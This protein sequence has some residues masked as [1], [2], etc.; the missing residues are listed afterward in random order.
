MPSIDLDTTAADAALLGSLPEGLRT[1]PLDQLHPHPKNP[2][3]DVGDVSELADSIREH[4]I[5]QPLLAVP[6]PG[7]PQRYRLVIGHRRHAAA[8]A[9]G[10]TEVSV[11][12]DP[13]LS[14][15]DQLELMLVENVQRSDLTVVEEADGYQGLL[16][17]GL[18]VEDAARKTGRSESTVRRRLK[19]VTL[20]DDAREKVH[21]GQAT[22]DDVAALPDQAEDPE[23]FDRL[24]A[25]LGTADFRWQIQQHEQIKRAA[26]QAIVDRQKLEE[27]LHERGI[28]VYASGDVA[29]AEGL[30]QDLWMVGPRD[31]D[32]ANGRESACAGWGFV[33]HSES[34]ANG[35]LYRPADSDD[36]AAPTVD[37]DPEEAARL[38]EE[39]EQERREF[40]AAQAAERRQREAIHGFATTSAE[41]RRRFLLD[42]IAGRKGSTTGAK[43][44]EA[45]VWFLGRMVHTSPVLDSGLW[46]DPS[47]NEDMTG[48][49]GIDLDA[50]AAAAA[51]QDVDEY[52]AIDQETL[53][54]ITAT[55]D[56][57]R[58]LAV[59]ASAVEP[60]SS[61]KWT[62]E[63]ARKQLI[64]PWY[65]LLSKLGYAP[66]S[67]ELKATTGIFPDPEPAV[68]AGG[69]D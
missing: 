40:E 57:R 26:A 68:T 66:S 17:L 38:R 30:R 43:A 60:I 23:A 18:T 44:A 32:W 45:L 4:G 25:K 39:A 6:D 54:V 9:A 21:A 67:I 27:L 56:A 46:F 24:V 55:K 20:P 42:A 16:D 10:L 41:L 47:E 22:L 62:N 50:I 2:R 1:I 52:D 61:W 36:A 58:L 8:I 34:S 3:R 35:Y 65:V 29:R 5:R 12:V 53:K 15:A 51:E 14:E 31:A 49:L 63:T 28:T 37:V 64:D 11:I 19:L 33:Y 7:D 48:W 59:I 13:S 69:D